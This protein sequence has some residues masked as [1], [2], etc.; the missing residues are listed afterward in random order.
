MT[1]AKDSA[2][3]NAMGGTELLKT[4]LEKRLSSD[5]LDNFQIFVSRVEEPFDETKIRIL[6][7]HDLA[8]DFASNHLAN[9]GWK[10]FHRIVFVSNWQ[11][12]SFIKRFSIPWSK[13]IVIQNAINP[14][15]AHKKPDDDIIRLGYWSTPHRGLNILIPVF[16]KLCQDYDNLELDVYSSFNL[17]GW[18]ERDEP[19]KDLF[20]KCRSHSRINYHG[21]VPN[22]DIRDAI[23]KIDILAYPSTWEETSCLALIEAMSGGCVCVHSN[24]GALP[25]T[26]AN[27]TMQYQ[28]LEDPSEHAGNFYLALRAAIDNL[29]EDSIQSRLASQVSYTNV[30]YNWDLRA[31]HWEAYLT[32]LLNESRELPQPVFE[33]RTS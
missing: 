24:Y 14:I 30:F 33:Y 25:E 9:E 11:M 4:E 31:R 6:W 20:D 18:K 32:S 27:W 10:N 5:L 21:S 22:Q 28:H 12:Q 23:K 8:E 3:T 1:F 13:C 16:D 29:R 2:S 17:Y 26:S 7:C 15:E 19:Y